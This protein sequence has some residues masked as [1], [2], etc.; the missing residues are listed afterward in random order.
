MKKII[1]FAMLLTV[2]TFSL[3]GCSNKNKTIDSSKPANAQRLSTNVSLENT[4]AQSNIVTNEIRI[5]AHE[6]EQLNETEL[7]SFSTKLGGKDTPRSHN[8][9]I[10]TSTL[11]ETI[12]KNGETFSF[13][14][15]IG[16]P[17]ADKGYQEA[18]SFD[19]DGKTI[20]TLGGRKLPS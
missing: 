4:N 12:V 18:D 10:T 1:S 6:S 20:Q 19:H 8:I 16:K 9:S 7:A 3:I 5:G 15:T 17:T 2:L 11:N 14:G 13:C